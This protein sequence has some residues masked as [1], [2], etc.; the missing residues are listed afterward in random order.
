MPIN[1]AFLA[2]L[3][4]SG[5]VASCNL[6]TSLVI[7]NNTFWAPDFGFRL[8]RSFEHG[9][10][11]LSAGERLNPGNGLFLTSRAETA[12]LGYG[13]SGLR[14]WSMNIAGYYVRALSVGNIQGGYGQLT[15]AFSMSHSIL[16][17]LSF[18]SSFN[19][20]KYQS[21]SF[22][23]Y[24]H[25]IYFASIGLGFSSRDIPVRLF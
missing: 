1:P 12:S 13:Y 17:H 24:N 4:P 3:C 22:A 10:A 6:P 16:P 7:N 23:A 8:S 9:V 15:G 2:I 11:Y 5:V 19:V 25:L 21:S 20:T 14:K 18:L